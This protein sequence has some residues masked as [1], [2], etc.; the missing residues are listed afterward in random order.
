V[1]QAQ[2]PLADLANPLPDEGLYEVL[3]AAALAEPIL[4]LGMV[5]AFL[6]AVTGLICLVTVKMARYRAL[7][8]PVASRTIRGMEKDR[9]A[10]KSD[11]KKKG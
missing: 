2:L 1:Q 6:L 4:A 3:Y 9:A 8:D 10:L 5:L 11:S 7:K